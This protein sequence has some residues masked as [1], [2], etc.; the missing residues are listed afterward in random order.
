MK[1]K[2][3]I[4]SSLHYAFFFQ[5]ML[6]LAVNNHE[7]FNENTA[8]N[9]SYIFHSILLYRAK[10]FPVSEIVNRFSLL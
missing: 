2:R 1:K 6:Y 5:K 10:S 3:A 4:T 9:I 7:P 8:I